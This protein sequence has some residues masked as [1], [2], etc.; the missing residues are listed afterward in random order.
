MTVWN[1]LSDIATVE[2]VATFVAGGAAV[3][4][5]SAVVTPQSKSLLEACK[6]D[7][8]DVAWRIKQL[9]P[10]QRE[11]IFALTKQGKCKSLEEIERNYIR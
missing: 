7:L 4:M 8:E 5:Y 1:V 11:E 2:S 6:K 10:R 9:T 3:N